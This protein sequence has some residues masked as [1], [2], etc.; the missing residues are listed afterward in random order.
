MDVGVTAGEVD[1]E[2]KMGQTDTYGEGSEAALG[3]PETERRS[4]AW[5]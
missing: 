4:Q 3:P 2:G 5:M 1:L